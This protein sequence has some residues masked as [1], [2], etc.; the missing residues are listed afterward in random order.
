MPM[1]KQQGIL[2]GVIQAKPGWQGPPSLDPARTGSPPPFATLV[3]N[4][5]FPRSGSRKT[6]NTLNKMG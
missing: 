4:Y 5:V 1:L 6:V 3:S 2:L